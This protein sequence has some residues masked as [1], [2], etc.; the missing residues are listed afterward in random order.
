MKH[1][2]TTKLFYNRYKYKLVL[3]TAL[4]KHINPSKLTR[5]S[6]ILDGLQRQAD[7]GQANLT[8]L[9]G[10]FNRSI[11]SEELYESKRIYK[12]LLR[13]TEYRTRAEGITLSV[14]S[15]NWHWLL[16]LKSKV[17]DPQE[18][19]RPRKESEK[20]IEAPNVIVVK[21]PPSYE[22]KVMLSTYSK[23]DPGLAEWIEANPT[24]AKTGKKTLSRIRNP[25]YTPSGHVYVR[26]L[27]VL[28][29]LSFMVSNIGRVD[30]LVYVADK[31]K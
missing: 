23:I 19:W 21:Q 26:D 18:L 13:S 20:T 1:F 9:T 5:L 11:T 27:K 12:E 31:D 10:M 25:R 6:E 29:L 17:D 28:N 15:N 8:F 7:A 4:A 30:K 24:L 22:F 16:K 2:E 14:Y 3:R